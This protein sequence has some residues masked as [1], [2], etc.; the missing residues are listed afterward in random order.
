[1]YII[2][3][4]IAA[5]IGLVLIAIFKESGFGS[6]EKLPYKKKKY[7]MTKVEHDFFKVLQQVVNNKYYIVPQVQ[8]SKLV[9]IDR[10]EKY[11]KTY[12][13]KID[14]K[15]VDFV[16]FDKEYFSPIM[17]IELDDNSH[18][19]EDRKTRDGF[20]D[21]VVEKI[22]MPIKHIKT[23]YSYNFQEIQSLIN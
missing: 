16:L 5:V 23:S 11:K 12:L 2:I 21:S 1:M 10:Y 8:L 7:L 4:I 13:N 3:F 19:R 17:I 14:R 9:G 15:S 6:E 20:V 18:E 22:G